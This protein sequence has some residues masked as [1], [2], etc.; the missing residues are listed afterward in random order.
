MRLSEMQIL[1]PHPSESQTSI[2]HQNYLARLLEHRVLGPILIH[3]GWGGGAQK[4]AFLPGSWVML[5]A[6]V[7]SSEYVWSIEAQGYRLQPRT[8]CPAEGWLTA[9]GTPHLLAQKRAHLQTMLNCPGN[10]ECLQ[11]AACTWS[12]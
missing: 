8:L 2:T 4:S 12:R 10:S 3:G 11:N 1:R 7:Q 5:R 9:T 6:L